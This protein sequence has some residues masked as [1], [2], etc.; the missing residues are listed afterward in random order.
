[1]RD[2]DALDVLRLLRAVPTDTLA[3]R[4]ALLKTSDLAG[5]VAVEARTQLAERFASR[6]A[7][8]V[9]MAVRAAG[10]DEDAETIAASLVALIEDLL[11]A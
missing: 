7:E 10:S 11:D 9:V 1:M 5:P 3:E 8:A 2:K 6:D 4:L